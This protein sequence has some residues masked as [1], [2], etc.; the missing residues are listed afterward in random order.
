MK[1]YLSEI[2]IRVHGDKHNECARHY[3]LYLTALSQRGAQYYGDSN[4]YQTLPCV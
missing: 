2:V 4:R 1:T 3:A